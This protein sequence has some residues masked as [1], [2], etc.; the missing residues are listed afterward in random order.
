MQSRLIPR[1]LSPRPTSIVAPPSKAWTLR[2]ILAAALS[3]TY[4]TLRGINTGDDAW[5]MIRGVSPI[6]EVDLRQDS[7]RLKK[8]ISIIRERVIDVGE[9]GFTFRVLTGVY[10]G[11][12]GVTHLIPRGS[13]MRRP[14]DAL[15]KALRGLNA[16]IDA[17]G[18]IIRIIGS[19]LIGGYLT[20]EGSISSQFISALLYLAPLT[21]GG[22]EITIR[23]PI[24]S[25]PYID[26]TIR[27]LREFGIDVRA[28][29][30]SIYVA[31]SQEYRPSFEEL[32]IPGDHSLAAFYVA[33]SA[34]MGVDI[35]IQNLRKTHAIESEYSFYK[36]AIEMGVPIVE[37]EDSLF[38]KGSEARGLAPIDVD[39]GDSPDIVM[40]LALLAAKARGKSR[41][42]GVEHLA[43]KESDRLMAVYD[44]LRC[45]GCDVHVD[46][47]QGVIEI[48]GS[49]EFEGGCIIDGRND[50]RVIVMAFIGGLVCKRQ[51][52][53]T[54]WEGFAKSWP[55]FLNDMARLGVSYDVEAQ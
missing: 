48:R 20:I 54:N 22:I 42:R 44:V 33:Y 41:I 35:E 18:P 45:L 30:N 52:G 12:E 13:L 1:P 53:I 14:I 49:C 40:P 55:S 28:E 23:P 4:V 46:K 51:I 31:G 19:R 29:G 9:S 36:L 47:E 38:V 39:L 37:Y 15:I 50:H 32:V 6:A 17:L 43:F 25:R 11:I 10:S 5:A 21:E 27:V 26:A 34:L 24:K 7:I 3:R 16:N 8:S 2:Y